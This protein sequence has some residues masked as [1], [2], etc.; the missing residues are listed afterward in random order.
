[1]S[2]KSF[3]PEYNQALGYCYASQQTSINPQNYQQPCGNAAVQEAI[4]A[5]T[6]PQTP[7][8]PP[9]GKSSLAPP[10]MQPV[11]GSWGLKSVHSP[12]GG[13]RISTRSRGVQAGM[14]P[15]GITLAA[16]ESDGMEQVAPLQS[17]VNAT[18]AAGVGSQ[19]PPAMGGTVMWFKDK[20]INVSF[21]HF[22]EAQRVR[23]E[24]QD[25]ETPRQTAQRI[26]ADPSMFPAEAS[27]K[28]AAPEKGP[29]PAQESG[30]STS[31]TV[32]IVEGALVAEIQQTDDHA[33]FLPNGDKQITTNTTSNKLAYKE[34][35]ATGTLSKTDTVTKADGSST[36]SKN[37]RSLLLDDKGNVGM[38]RSVAREKTL[39]DASKREAN[40]S[41]SLVVG[42]DKV[43]IKAAAG[44]KQTDAKG[45]TKGISVTGSAAVTEHAK[46]AQGGLKVLG[47]PGEKSS[48]GALRKHSMGI[49]GG[50]EIE[51]MPPAP[52][53]DGRW[54]VAYKVNWNTGLSAS[55]GPM[56]GGQK[57]AG[58]QTGVKV[59]TDYEDALAFYHS[60]ALKAA[61]INGSEDLA[62]METGSSHSESEST[63]NDGGFGLD[64]VLVSISAGITALEKSGIDYHKVNDRQV[65]VTV[66]RT[67]GISEG[68][69]ISGAGVG[70]QVGRQQ[71][72]TGKVVLL[73][74]LIDGKA[75]LDAIVRT[76]KQPKS[77]K[78]VKILRYLSMQQ[79]GFGAGFQV[80]GGAVEDRGSTT[81]TVSKEPGGVTV[82]SESKR[83]NSAKL[84]VNVPGFGKVGPGSSR[85]THKLKSTER[86]GNR[87]LSVA[88]SVCDKNSAK[89][90][91]ECLYDATG[92]KIDPTV[93][94][95]SIGEVT[96]SQT[97][98]PKQRTAFLA[99][100][101]RGDVGS[102][103]GMP[104]DKDRIAA[105]RTVLKSSQDPIHIQQAF[106]QYIEDGGSSS[107][108]EMD[109]QV[110]DGIQ[111]IEVEGSR[112]FT[113]APGRIALEKKIA[114]YKQQLSAIEKN[115]A[116]GTDTTNAR[117][118]LLEA[119][120]NT[121]AGERTRQAGMISE[122]S[123]QIP[124]ATLRDLQS[125]NRRN[126]ETLSELIS[127][128]RPAKSPTAPVS[129]EGKQLAKA[130]QTLE[131]QQGEVKAKREKCEWYRDGHAG[132][133]SQSVRRKLS[134]PGLFGTSLGKGAERDTYLG[135]DR[136][137]QKAKWWES[138]VATGETIYRRVRS[139]GDLSAT[140][141][142]IKVVID[143]HES[144]IDRYDTA[145][146]EYQG[147][148]RRWQSTYPALFR[149]L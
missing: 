82:D 48:D 41:G 145:I 34:G 105:L 137:V 47:G 129:R 89:G 36:S 96:V 31:R 113:G 17:E 77:T 63:E 65:Q 32:G 61:S 22:N 12:A 21:E 92:V 132:R 39:A 112:V 142:A 10:E 97:Y 148:Q 42:P 69:A 108:R 106:D 79:S 29:G 30:T 28:K 81:T 139:N 53:Q 46:S 67:D 135:I 24:Q 133:N 128:A 91:A 84:E 74:D 70:I 37:G 100:V 7:A 54:K 75:A 52:T 104:R 136:L 76:K 27:P 140:L 9:Q 149:G 101:K 25:G 8:P 57:D 49:D 56:K 45:N 122:K 121:R 103:Y 117:Q 86:N 51:I 73:V 126:I 93:T 90:T 95:E 62:K 11:E 71:A 118:R 80:P 120:D 88:T 15:H 146:S 43:A 40:A 44:V 94:G 130:Q 19:A 125:H 115:E 13:D 72:T 102:I 143:Y 64:L 138:I 1:M 123:R 26:G 141:K 110:G 99:A 83:V 109:R 33:V 111:D 35:E 119:I 134:Q 20:K 59:Y 98:T 18:A 68:V 14:G 78:G 107:L 60:G 114:G 4:Q 87:G 2:Q 50:G 85:E 144:A 116:S 127:Q 66:W 131:T 5:K 58:S 16:Q 147:I 124:L 6:A 38:G 23:E 3:R 55:I